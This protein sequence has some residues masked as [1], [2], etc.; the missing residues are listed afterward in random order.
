MLNILLHMGSVVPWKR[1]LQM[2][3]PSIRRKFNVQLIC[4]NRKRTYDRKCLQCFYHLSQN[5]DIHVVGDVAEHTLESWH[6]IIR[7]G[8]SRKSIDL[9]TQGIDLTQRRKFRNLSLRCQIITRVDDLHRVWVSPNW[10]R[11]M[12]R[13]GKGCCCCRP[14]CIRLKYLDERDVSKRGGIFAYYFLIVGGRMQTR[15]QRRIW[16]RRSSFGLGAECAYGWS[17]KLRW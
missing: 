2:D 16:I 11:A 1:C 5:F 14:A 13:R 3:G 8:R 10:D 6:S 4:R 15:L 9:I 12:L 7:Q 17:R